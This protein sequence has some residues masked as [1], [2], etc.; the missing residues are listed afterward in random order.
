[1]TERRAVVAIDGPA[2]AGKSTLARALAE[3]LDLAYVNTGAMYRALTAMALR[4]GVDPGDA[5]ALRMVAET[6]RFSLDR[7]RPPSLLIDCRPP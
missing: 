7:G 2:G 4:R 6:L 1:M 3:R 5:E